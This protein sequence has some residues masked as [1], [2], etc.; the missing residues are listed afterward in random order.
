M[1][2]RDRWDELFDEV[3][4][5]TYSARLGLRDASAEA[6][7]AAALAGAEPP[8]EVLD[9]PCGFGRHSVPLAAVGFR[10]TGVDR[11]PVQLDAARRDAT[12]HEN[13][14]FVRADHRSLAAWDDASF[15][16][17]LNL[18]SSLGYRGEEG[19][20][21]TLGEFRRVLRPEGALVIETMHR[22]R[23]IAIFRETDWEELTNEGLVLERREFDY[24]A[25]EVETSHMLVERDG[26][27]RSLTY[28]IRL[29][30]ATELAG[31][32]ARVGFTRV[33]LFGSYEREPLSRDTRLIAL[34]RP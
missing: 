8:A 22:D 31:L 17:V 10:V 5:R 14:R 2:E 20:L 32:L 11:S 15:D 4:L 29:Y 9:A 28:R 30:T 34:A 33:E 16:L 23:L 7:A 19:D 1:S 6:L 26:T 21:R 18:F 13:P 27:R 3:Y 24:V 12:D 25:G